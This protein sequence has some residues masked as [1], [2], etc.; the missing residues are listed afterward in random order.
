MKNLDAATASMIL[1]RYCVSKIVRIWC[2]RRLKVNGN[3]TTESALPRSVHIC[4]TV[5]LLLLLMSCFSEYTFDVFS[6]PDPLLLLL[7]WQ[8]QYQNFWFYFVI[9]INRIVVFSY[10]YEEKFEI[11]LTDVLVSVFVTKTSLFTH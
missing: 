10:S 2:E 8:S 3:Y 6:S 5:M 11:T 4:L 1:Q 9:V 7:F